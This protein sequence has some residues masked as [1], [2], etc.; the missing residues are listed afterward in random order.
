MGHEKEVSPI[1]LYS[2]L[3]HQ[4]VGQC[5][6]DCACALEPCIA[7]TTLSSPAFFDCD[8]ACSLDLLPHLVQSTDV[9]TWLAQKEA[10]SVSLEDHWR[11]YCNPAGPVGLAVLN[12]PAQEVLA[13][14]DTPA[15][16]LAAS[17]RLSRL[18][19]TEFDRAAGSLA[20][21][22]LLRPA[23]MATSV[24]A[25]TR[26]LAAW[27]HVT[28]ACDLAC[29]YC[30][31]HKRP[32]AMSAEVGCN[33]V[34]RLVEMAAQH[35][36]STLKLKYAGGEPTLNFSVVQAVHAHAVRRTAQA[37]LALDEV[38]LT[39]GVG[40]TEAMLDFIAQAGMR[41]MVSLDGGRETHDRVRAR[42]DGASTH[43][44][45]VRTVERALE[46][47]LQPDISITVTALNLDGVPEAV[48]FALERTLPF[49]LNFHRECSLPASRA[50]SGDAAIASPL[51]PDPDR[52]V[53]VVTSVFDLVR[54]YPAYP[55][56]LAGIL[57]RI[58]LDVPHSHACSAGRDYVA[59]DMEGRVSACQML[60]QTPWT[61]LADKDPLSTVRQRGADLFRSVEERADCASCPWR[62]AC[63][64]GCPLMR[65]TVLHDRYCQVYQILLPQLV[66]LEAD[67]L[68]AWQ[69]AAT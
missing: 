16:R 10:F 62:M 47:G 2:R 19:A 69:H 58:R 46:R 57:D 29:P 28:E 24:Q 49:N 3:L 52:L 7:P 38:L 4:H 42:R 53:D 15:T 55:L 50:E 9:T 56:P 18:S 45:V 12:A 17:E 61:D 39:N 44:A 33:V 34:D 68:I 67:R 25:Q 66:R 51:S 26:V 40:M 23:G 32:R 11:A 64:G 36:Y 13:V 63:S 5:D 37:S 20:R 31:V 35:G 27:M 48:A 41:L 60:L 1:I 22:G 14:F 8:C 30:Y 6:C 43:A 21:I 54:T 59:V 65:D